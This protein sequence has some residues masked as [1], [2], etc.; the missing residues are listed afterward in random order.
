MAI[1]RQH[2]DAQPREGRMAGRAFS[3]WLT[4]YRR[5]WRGTIISGFLGPLFFLLAMG[6]G[7]GALV[8]DGAGGGV[9]GVAYVSFIAPGVLAAQA[10]QTAVGESTF[11]VLGAVKWQRQYHAMLAAP[12]GISDIVVGH[13]MFVTM[14]LAITSVTF[15]LVAVAVGAITTPWVVLAVLAAVLT[16]LAFATPIFAFAARQD[17][18]SGFNVIFRFV[19]MPMFLFSGT[20]FPIDQLPDVLEVIAWATPLWHGVDLCRSLVMQTATPLGSLGHVAYLLLWVGGG[21]W[22]ALAAFRRRLMT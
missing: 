4:N 1:T 6:F 19:V 5:V 18:D 15:A 7:L 12:L 14:R 22:L 20:F 8:D 13:L 2:S 16:G 9:N 10:M 3:F 11:P 17:T 21:L